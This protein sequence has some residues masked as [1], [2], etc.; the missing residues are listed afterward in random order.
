MTN[1]TCPLINRYSSD[2]FRNIEEYI[3]SGKDT[4]LESLDIGPLF[5]EESKDSTA[6]DHSNSMPKLNP[7]YYTGKLDKYRQPILE[8]ND[9][10]FGRFFLFYFLFDPHSGYAN[11]IFFLINHHTI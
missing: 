4:E 1:F 8:I 7:S 10:E 6:S 5:G 2:E 11:Y 3:S 9:F